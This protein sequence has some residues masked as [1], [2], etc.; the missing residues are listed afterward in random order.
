[1]SR[2]QFQLEDLTINLSKNKTQITHSNTRVYLSLESKYL[3]T[4]QNGVIA[5]RTFDNNDSL[6]G[7]NQE[8]V[9]NY[10]RFLG[11][12]FIHLGALDNSGFYNPKYDISFCFDVEDVIAKP[13]LI[14]DSEGLMNLLMYGQNITTEELFKKEYT[15]LD[16]IMVRELDLNKAMFALTYTKTAHK[17]ATNLLSS[18]KE[19]NIGQ[20]RKKAIERYFK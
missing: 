2:R 5:A 4:Y 19:E 8:Y 3:E 13:H 18:L 20:L 17:R 6:V 7:M 16:E 10:R 14:C 15:G 11:F 9:E 12:R 1:M